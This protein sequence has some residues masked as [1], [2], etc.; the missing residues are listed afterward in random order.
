MSPRRL[1]AE[2]IRDAILAGNNQLDLT[3]GGTLL[4]DYV[5]YVDTFVDT[6]RGILATQ[7]IGRTFHPYYSARRSIY[8]PMIRQKIPEIFNVFDL[9]DPSTVTAR[10][11]ETTVAPQALFLMNSG[12]IREQAFH[13]ARYLLSRGD[14]SDEDRIFLTYQ[15]LLGRPPRDTEIASAIDYVGTVRSALERTH[16]SSE[17]H[18]PNGAVLAI[19]AHRTPHRRKIYEEV[20]PVLENPGGVRL[21]ISVTSSPWPF[22]NTKDQRANW[23]VL[24]PI[25]AAS[26]NNAAL[27]IGTDQ[28]VNIPGNHPANNRYSIV[29]NTS[30]THITAVRL[31]V[32]PEQEQPPERSVPDLF[33]LSEFQVHASS[34]ADSTVPSSDA[35]AIRWQHATLRLSDGDQS[36]MPLVDDDPATYWHVGPT[37][38]RPGVVVFETMDHR[39]AAWQSWCRAVFCLNE[40]VYLE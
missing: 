20:K 31:E 16:P 15:R 40:F 17:R 7:L 6:K 10:R 39:V 35:D 3:I 25:S 18:F 33:V 21:R 30:L 13:M 12:F 1:E 26:G 29:A 28:T 8:L 14:L 5:R 9:G 11:G 19:T 27:M 37:P 24:S 4:G 2:E 36:V 23:E 32:L 22:A 38:D 34:A